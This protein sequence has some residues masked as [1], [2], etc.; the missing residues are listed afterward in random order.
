LVGGLGPGE[1]LTAVVPA[2]DEGFDGA[3]EVLDAVKVPRR[4]AC[5]VMIPKKISINRYHVQPAARGEG[6]AP[7][8]AYGIDSTP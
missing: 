6:A 8:P 7:S 4:M 3:D 2:V 1:R 5:R